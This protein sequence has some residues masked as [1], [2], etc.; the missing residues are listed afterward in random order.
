MRLVRLP[1]LFAA[2]SAVRQTSGRNIRGCCPLHLSH[3]RLSDQ[4]STVVFTVLQT[5]LTT[6]QQDGIDVGGIHPMFVSANFLHIGF[7]ALFTEYQ[8]SRPRHNGSRAVER[9]SNKSHTAVQLRAVVGLQCSG[10]WCRPHKCRALDS[11]VAKE[12]VK[13]KNLL[14]LSQFALKIWW[15]KWRKWLEEICMKCVGA[16]ENGWAALCW[17]WYVLVDGAAAQTIS[18]MRKS[19]LPTVE[20]QSRS[21]RAAQCR[22]F[23]PFLLCYPSQI[24]DASASSRSRQRLSGLETPTKLHTTGK[25][26]REDWRMFRLNIVGNADSTTLFAI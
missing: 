24:S 19:L 22:A 14:K 13:S 10:Y 2:A 1:L 17:D 16:R 12:F 4:R 21:T 26:A 15:S 18:M 23:I 5:R 8:S 20:G 25:N 6:H 7:P 3:I 9:G 11:T